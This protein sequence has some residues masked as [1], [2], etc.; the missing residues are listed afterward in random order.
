MSRLT[1]PNEPNTADAQ[2]GGPPSC[3]SDAPPPQQTASRRLRLSK[4]GLPPAAEP[5][6]YKVVSSLC[7]LLLLAL[8]SVSLYRQKQLVAVLGLERKQHE[9][10]GTISS[11]AEADFV[12]FIILHDTPGDLDFVSFI[13][14]SPTHPYGT[15]THCLT[16]CLPA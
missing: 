6:C 13:Q 1:V 11:L 10:K 9:V 3:H 12:G 16:Y 4:P 8:A 14:L 7:L 5:L 2:F 15:H